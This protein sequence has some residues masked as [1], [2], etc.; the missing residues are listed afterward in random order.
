MHLLR[1]R[2]YRAHVLHFA[3]LLLC[4]SA[5]VMLPL[6]SNVDDPREN[7]EMETVFNVNDS[8]SLAGDAQFTQ[9]WLY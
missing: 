5:F 4:A 7:Y 2:W 9:L 1:N 3:I 6:I 8:W